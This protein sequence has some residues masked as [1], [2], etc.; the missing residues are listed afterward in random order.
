MDHGDLP[1]WIE[2][3][4]GAVHYPDWYFY[5]NGTLSSS[6][7]GSCNCAN[8]ISHHRQMHGS[9]RLCCIA[10]PLFNN[11]LVHLETTAAITHYITSPPRAHKGQS[12]T[13]KL[14]RPLEN[15]THACV[16]PALW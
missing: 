1:A 15:T 3:S 16:D 4:A 5:R 14:A 10:R 2:D 9:K 12:H 6:K 11:M 8:S 13:D 7:T